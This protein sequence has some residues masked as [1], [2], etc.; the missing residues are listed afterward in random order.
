MK[1]TFAD[2]LE[3]KQYDLAVVMAAYLMTCEDE[4][5]SRGPDD[6]PWM[7]QADSESATACRILI[8]DMSY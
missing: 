7:R 3:L 8:S 2:A 4:C 5:F 6:S 1:Q